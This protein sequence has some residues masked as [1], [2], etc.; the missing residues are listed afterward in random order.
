MIY[1]LRGLNGATITLSIDAPNLSAS[2]A[3]I[4]YNLLNPSIPST[5]TECLWQK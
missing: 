2:P 3:P 4:N 1:H 5:T